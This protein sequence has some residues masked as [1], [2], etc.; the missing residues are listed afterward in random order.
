MLEIINI[1]ILAVVIALV[2][3]IIVIQAQTYKQQIVSNSVGVTDFHANTFSEHDT[4]LSGYV[5]SLVTGNHF[6]NTDK[7]QELLLPKEQRDNFAKDFKN[8]YFEFRDGINQTSDIGA[9]PVD[10]INKFTYQDFEQVKG[11]KIGD[12]YDEILNVN[13]GYI[14]NKK[15]SNLQYVSDSGE[16]L[17]GGNGKMYDG[18]HWVTNN[19]SSKIMM[20]NDMSANSSMAY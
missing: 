17:D 6:T 9:D 20:A 3:Y 10:N 1:L 16:L 11:R 14:A 12:V 19:D 15:D 2:I 13:N 7:S 8:K 18:Y 5:G 4:K